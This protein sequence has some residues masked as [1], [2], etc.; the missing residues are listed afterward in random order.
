MISKDDIKE[1]NQNRSPD[2]MDSLI[3]IFAENVV[4]EEANKEEREV[5][6][7]KKHEKR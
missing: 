3:L 1:L 4:K 6:I 2:F 7:E 5:I